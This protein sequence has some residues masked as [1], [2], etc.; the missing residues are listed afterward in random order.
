MSDYGMKTLSDII[1]VLFFLTSY[2]TQIFL[3]HH[4][5]YIFMIKKK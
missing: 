3:L 2:L 4:S 1:V 5:D